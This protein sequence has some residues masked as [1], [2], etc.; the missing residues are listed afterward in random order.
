[1]R[2]GVVFFVLPLVGGACHRDRPAPTSKLEVLEVDDEDHPLLAAWGTTP[3]PV[4]VEVENLP[5]RTEYAFCPGQKDDEIRHAVS[6]ATPPKGTHFAFGRGESS[7]GI[8]GTRSWLV[9]DEPILEQRNVTS[10]RAQFDDV[11]NRWA[12]W[13]TLDRAGAEAFERF[14][15]AHVN[16][17]IA[18]TVDGVV[19]SAPIV[20]TKIAGGKI[21]I[22]YGGAADEEQGA[23]ELARAL[24][25]S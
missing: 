23:K 2:P 14:T 18:I 1:M 17:R 21:Q 11:S 9:R 8:E 13:V 7:S 15:A 19:H 16:H 6:S 20:R 25:G 12:V 10:A 24:G 4:T 22:T 5:L 3:S